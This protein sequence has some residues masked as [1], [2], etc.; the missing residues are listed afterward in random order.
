MADLG[1]GAG[2]KTMIHAKAAQTAAIALSLLG[3]LLPLSLRAADEPPATSFVTL[4]FEG[5]CDPQNNR[6]W[7]LSS[8]T[9]K[10]IA[11][12]VRWHAAGGKDLVEQFFAAPGAKRE[13]GCA[14]E[15]TVE[16]AEFANF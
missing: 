9:F 7:L 6:L 13:I 1:L 3:T 8:H 16:A 11:V 10:T 2:G 15:A 5:A 12:T 14:A 4:N